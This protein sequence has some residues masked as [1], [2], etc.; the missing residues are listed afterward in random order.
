[1]EVVDSIIPDQLDPVIKQ[2]V[3]LAIDAVDQKV[4]A[5]EKL[6]NDQRLELAKKYMGELL[7]L[8]K[9]DLSDVAREALIEA[10]LWLRHRVTET[11]EASTK[12]TG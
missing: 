10:E 7:T 6:T 11:G 3:K 5:Y 2:I 8:Y 9:R 1:L 4:K 12:S